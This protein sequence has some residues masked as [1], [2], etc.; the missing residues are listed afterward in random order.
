MKKVILLVTLGVAG[1]VS[2]KSTVFKTVKN[3]INNSAS[4][5]VIE[6]E[7]SKTYD[8]RDIE[9]SKKNNAMFQL[10]GVT[11]T[12]F[13]ADGNVTGQDMFTSDQTSLENCQMW[14]SLVKHRLQVKGFVLAPL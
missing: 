5:K 6:L 12:Y 9:Q 2:A 11:V 8:L 4:Y 14:Q 13:D 10:C 3:Q 1:I 7:Q